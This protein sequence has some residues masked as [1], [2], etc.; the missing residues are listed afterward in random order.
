MTKPHNFCRVFGFG[1]C[2][3][4]GRSFAM[5]ANNPKGYRF[6]SK[7]CV[8]LFRWETAPHIFKKAQEI[9]H[10]LNRTARCDYPGEWLAWASMRSRCTKHPRYKGI[11]TFSER[12]SKF[13]NFIADMGPKPTANH[14]LDRIDNDGNYEPGNCRWATAKE[15]ASNRKR[16]RKTAGMLEGLI[17]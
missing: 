9:A 17:G 16:F 12:W 14:S 3:F 11:I 10:R 15:Q 8:G 4:C 5:R 7:R 2:E 1:V 13:G 6:C